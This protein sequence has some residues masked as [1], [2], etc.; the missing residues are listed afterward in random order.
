VE[1]AARDDFLSIGKNEWIV[2]GGIHLD[3][4]DAL[5]KFDR[6]V[7]NSMHLQV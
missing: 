7:H 4:N 2:R 3:S 5:H 1:I 6:V